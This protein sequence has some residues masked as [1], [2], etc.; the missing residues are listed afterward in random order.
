MET[1]RETHTLN[2]EQLVAIVNR[3]DTRLFVLQLK[4]DR[5]AELLDDGANIY[6][7]EISSLMKKINLQ[8]E[9]REQ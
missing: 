2:R 3:L 5:L 1:L 6:D 8:F 7:D 4:W 9:R